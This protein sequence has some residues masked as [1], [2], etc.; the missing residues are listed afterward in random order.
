MLVEALVT[1]SAV[2]TLAEGV[3]DWLAGCNVMQSNASIGSPAEHR[4][5]THLRTVIE[6]DRFRVSA[7][8]CN[9][10]EHPRHPKAGKR[11]VGLEGKIFV[12]TVVAHA[13]NTI[14]SACPEAVVNEIERPSLIGQQWLLSDWPAAKGEF[15]ANPFSDLERCRSV[16]PLNPFMVVV[17]SVPSRQYDEA[18][19]PISSMTTGLLDQPAPQGLIG[20]PSRLVMKQL[21]VDVEPAACSSL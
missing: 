19:L 6:D 20:Y 7:T 8:F 11:E 13:Q 5:R 4:Q 3:L 12:R 2:E 21:A 1:Q 9:G 17:E 18:P 10:I 14:T 15:T 16:D